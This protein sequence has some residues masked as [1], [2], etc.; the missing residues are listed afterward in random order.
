M[1]KTLIGMTAILC[2]AIF[3]PAA[4]AMQNDDVVIENLCAPDFVAEFNDDESIL[5]NLDYQQLEKVRI[6]LL[7]RG[8]NPGFSSELDSVSSA[9]LMEALR[10][11]QAEYDLP[12]TAQVDGATLAALSIPIQ[13]SRPASEEVLRAKPSR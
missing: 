6:E 8:F 13:K 12:V 11:F 4:P 7:E 9:Q 2:V 3:A 5:A 1:P 10:Q